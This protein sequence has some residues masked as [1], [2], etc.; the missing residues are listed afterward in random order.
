MY[1]GFMK[2]LCAE[3]KSEHAG[4]RLDRFLADEIAEL[5]RSRIKALIEAGAVRLQLKD[6]VTIIGE[7]RSPVIAGA[8]Y[9]VELPEPISTELIPENIPLS[10][11]YEDEHLLLVDKPAGMAVHPAPGHP[12]GTL[13]NA[14]LHYCR[15]QLSGI[16]GVERPGIV[17]RIDKDTTGVLA[18]AKSEQAHMGLSE[19]FALHDIDRAYLAVSR[20]APRPRSGTIE[21]KIARSRHDRKKMAAFSDMEHPDGRTAITHY[22]VHETYGAMSRKEPVPVAALIEC[23]LETGRTHQIRVHMAH[24]GNP[25]LGDP[26]YSR[27]QGLK[28]EGKSPEHDAARAV[29][30]GFKR[31][32]LHAYRLGFVHPVSGKNILVESPLPDDFV[33]LTAALAAI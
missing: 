7:V 24:I 21:T 17:H 15:G 32:A 8:V 4:L 29:C 33:A 18:V 3:A 6:E 30:R 9:R 13:V 31:Q 11:L 2:D 22:K 10:V 12:S 27:Q 1:T 25:L 19:L 14:L 16:G 23:R 20:G 28:I 26:L 5:S